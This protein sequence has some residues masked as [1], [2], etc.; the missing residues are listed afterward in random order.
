MNL[1]PTIRHYSVV[2]ALLF[3]LLGATVAL[4]CFDLGSLNTPAAMAI[5]AIKAMLIIVFFMHLRGTKGA[6]L[7][8]AL[9]GFFW[10]GILF[11]LTFSDYVSR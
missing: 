2:A 6:V 4:T 7:L 10:L 11:V 8:Y 9:A 5:S 1:P 3:A